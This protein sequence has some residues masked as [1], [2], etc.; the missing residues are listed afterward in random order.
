M[1]PGPVIQIFFIEPG[2][3]VPMPKM[4]AIAPVLVV[5][6]VLA[7]VDYWKEKVGFDRAEVYGDPPNFAMV[8]KDGLTIMLAQT[9]H[10]VDPPPANWKVVEKT[11]QVY[12]WV[13]DASAL[14]RELQDR[15]ATIDFTLYDTPW[16]TR[17]FGIQDLDDHD[18]AFGQII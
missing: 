5:K 14:Y 12:I 16:G 11:N 18:I 15:G 17:E 4:T 3:V 1:N 8:G 7:S 6:D 13:D 9:P 10:G 2:T